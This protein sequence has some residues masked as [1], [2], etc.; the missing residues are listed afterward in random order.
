MSSKIWQRH[1]G[2]PC[3][4][5]MLSERV[6]GDGGTEKPIMQVEIIVLTVQLDTHIHSLK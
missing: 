1:V 5:Q 2:T 4:Q 3:Q 6:S